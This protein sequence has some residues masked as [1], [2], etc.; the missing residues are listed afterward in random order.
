MFKVVFKK[1]VLVVIVSFFLAG[2]NSFAEDDSI[3]N[4]MDQLKSRI[5][6]LENRLNEQ[7]KC[8]KD[9]KQCILNQDKKISEYEERFSQ[10]D[11]DLHRQEGSPIA[12]AEGLEIGVGATMVIQGTNNINDATSGVAKKE[13]RVDASYSTDITIGKEFKETSGKAFMHLEA[14]KGNGLEDNLTLYSDVNRDAGDGENA[15]VTELWYEQALLNDKAVATFGKI[16]PTAYFDNNEA[17][18]DETS[19][20]LGRIFR[21]SPAIEFPDNT[22]GMRI[23]YMPLEFLELG[24]GILDGDGDWEKIGDN[25]FNIGQVTFK[26]N[27]FSQQ[28]NYRLYGW[29]NNTY[30]TKWND[31]DKQKENSYGFGLSFDQKT[32]DITTLFCR[33]GWQDPKVY[34]PD[35]KA[36]EDGFEYSLE[37]SW[38]AG[39]QLEGKP[40]GREKDV[41]GFAV[42]QVIPSDDYKKA[43]TLSVA[44]PRAKA[45]GHLETYYRIY[46]NDHLS[47]SPDIQYIWN[48]FGKDI[49]D[50]TSSVFI[51]GMRAQVDF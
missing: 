30:H 19:Q 12:I 32:N 48:P 49:S 2:N 14:G 36:T 45:E 51:G 8:M 5:Q 23:A 37:Q 47:V 40:W 33:Y 1:F 35:N 15:Q 11:K 41:L 39:L 20:F 9:Q 21:N 28:G 3:R 13:S 24:Y 26:T 7:D 25:L 44:E 10:F 27:F 18:N 29:N 4:E 46:V 16:D 6:A 22:A 31:A 38:S 50:D 43:G 17:A 42:G 34:N